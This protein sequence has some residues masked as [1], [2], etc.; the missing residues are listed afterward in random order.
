MARQLLE[1]GEEVD[2]LLLLDSPAPDPE[3]AVRSDERE[4]LE[5][6]I[7]Q[8]GGAGFEIP[9]EE[10]S[11]I[12]TDDWMDRIVEL[13]RKR[14]ALPPSFDAAQARRHWQVVR[15]NVRAVESYVPKGPCEV[16]SLLFRATE[17]PEEIGERTSRGWERW[18]SGPLEIRDV[19][20][21]HAAPVRD[22]GAGLVASHLEVRLAAEETAPVGSGV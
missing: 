11:G 1:R 4:M 2:R 19:E 20:G 8:L 12:P 16:R 15:A 7:R 13:A 17:Q 18:L 3:S 5:G 10:L 6:M 22:P 14:G 21:D 9:A